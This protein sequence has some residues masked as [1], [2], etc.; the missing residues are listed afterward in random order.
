MCLTITCQMAQGTQS[1]HPNASNLPT[2]STSTSGAGKWNNFCT[3]LAGLAKAAERDRQA[4]VPKS[5]LIAGTEKRF[6]PGVFRGLAELTL[7]TAYKIP[8]VSNPDLQR[9]AATE[10]GDNTYLRCEHYFETH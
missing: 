8:R 1:S 5:I 6:P 7:N 3:I 10:F 9:R 2:A 4:G